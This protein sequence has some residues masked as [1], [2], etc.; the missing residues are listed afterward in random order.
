MIEENCDGRLQDGVPLLCLHPRQ[1]FLAQRFLPMVVGRAGNRVF[2]T[3]MVEVRKEVSDMPCGNAIPAEDAGHQTEKD[4]AGRE[5]DRVPAPE[6]NPKVQLELLSGEGRKKAI[7]AVVIYNAVT[8]RGIS[9]V[10]N[11]K[12]NPF[13]KMPR[14]PKG[15]RTKHSD[16]AYPINRA[17]R[18]MLYSAVLQEYDR[19][20]SEEELRRQETKLQIS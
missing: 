17:A 8:I 4:V 2:F 15:A 13:V 14:A 7:G 20:R 18:E 12:K 11:S 16:I 1:K 10:E 3:P 9:V 5:S 19:L 6:M